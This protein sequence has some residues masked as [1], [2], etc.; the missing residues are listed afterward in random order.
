MDGNMSVIAGKALATAGPG[1]QLFNLSL[2]DL[3]VLFTG[4]VVGAS[5]LGN[6]PEVEQKHSSAPVRMLE[7]VRMAADPEPA[8][9]AIEE[10]EP[11]RMVEELEPMR[12]AA[13]E[14]GPEPMRELDLKHEETKHDLPLF[15]RERAPAE[16]S[17]IAKKSPKRP[18]VIVEDQDAMAIAPAP[19]SSSPK[20][21]RGNFDSFQRETIGLDEVEGMIAPDQDFVIDKDLD[22][23]LHECE[24]LIRKKEHQYRIGLTKQAIK[25]AR[26]ECAEYE[27][28]R[29]MHVVELEKIKRN[30]RNAS[31][32]EKIYIW[33]ETLRAIAKS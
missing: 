3:L 22:I 14:S 17:F 5:G 1:S 16:Y 26:V 8:R 20:K 18:R 15:E 24:E 6:A 21:T 29:N 27:S 13:E 7:S 9:V 19:K 2:A 28:K 10:P 12:M 23:S 25:K 30:Q 33:A 11:M 32:F 31:Q 4:G